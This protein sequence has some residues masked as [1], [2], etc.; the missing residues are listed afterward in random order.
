[1]SNSPSLSIV[2]PAYNEQN[3]IAV[4]LEKIIQYLQECDFSSEVV[5]VDDGSSD[6][7][8]EIIE[9]FYEKPIPL[10]LIHF[11]S[12]HGKG[13]AIKAGVQASKGRYILF[14]DADLS[15][16]ITEVRKL[17][18]YLEKDYDIAIGS[19]A[20]QQSILLVRQSWWRQGMGKIFNRLIRLFV[21]KGI[22]DTQCGFKCFK[23]D[24]AKKL[25]SL[26]L[27]SGFAFDVEILFLA[28]RMNYKIAEVP[29][30][31]RNDPE[32]KVNPLID[33]CRMILDLV[34]L[35][36]RFYR[37]KPD[38]IEEKLTTYS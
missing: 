18:D 37:N 10:K 25:F 1:M 36:W 9:S 4:T 28:S 22:K 29:V 27:L 3:R 17:L 26:S 32:S 20:L 14:T 30:T 19:R 23:K 2:I 5:V 15:T 35:K 24:V 8:K 13:W 34:K 38:F 7:T 16:P 6:K 31:W 33:S 11:S 12:N 21:L